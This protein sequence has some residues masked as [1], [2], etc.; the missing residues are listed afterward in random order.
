MTLQRFHRTA[1]LRVLFVL[2]LSGACWFFFN[3]LK[4]NWVSLSAAGPQFHAA[5]FC[6]ALI[7]VIVSYLFMTMAWR[8]AINAWPSAGKITFRESFAVVNITQ[9]AKYLPGKVWS[10]AF[11]MM[12]MGPR[13]IPKSYIVYINIY[14]TISLLM[15]SL[16]IALLYMLLFHVFFPGPVA[17][18][19]FC[20]ACA[21]YCTFVFLNGWFFRRIVV[22]INRM[23]RTD[24]VFYD[25]KFSV[26]IKSQVALFASNVIWGCSGVAL[27]FGIGWAVPCDKLFPVLAITLFSDLIGFIT[28]VSPAGLGVREGTMFFLL[29]G[30]ANRRITLLL[31]LA[32]RI[33]TMAS[34]LI[35]CAAGFLF[36]REFVKKKAIGLS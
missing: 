15:T 28:V 13:N 3:E 36:F 8:A 33:V 14:M 4:R 30:V 1:V 23:F 19:L 25:S 29:A 9:M 31:P 12:I 6:I 26:L 18:L 24:I 16:C 21:G 17:A 11:Q 7:F 20:L 34:D 27:C 35:L 5:G 10:Y 2:V 32:L 22:L